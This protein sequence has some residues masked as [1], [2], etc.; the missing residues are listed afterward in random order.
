MLNCCFF[1]KNIL[2]MVQVCAL[3]SGSNGNCYY[4]GNEHE[5]VLI[6]AGINC[7]QILLRFE[8]AGLNPSKVKAIFIT[9]EHS[10]HVC[11]AKV[12]SKKLCVP[13][14]LTRGTYLNLIEPSRPQVFR[15]VEPGRELTI[16]NITV[17]PFRKKHD[18]A[19]PCSYRVEIEGR[20]IGVLTD[21]GSPC[22]ESIANLRLC[23]ILFLESNYD[24]KSLW[25]GP[26]PWPLKKRIASDLGHLSNLQALQLVEQHANG[27][28][29][30]IFLSHL[31]GE[32]NSPKMAAEAFLPL[33]EKYQ[34]ELTSRHG[35]GNVL[36]F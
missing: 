34:I 25:E 32:N 8:A 4:I 28:L 13:V 22:E 7:K 36:C 29:K 20:N 14:F 19:Q 16:G 10:D 15:F 6:D 35:A 12:L 23:E 18:A 5:A 24:E 21:L 11:G 26:Y 2:A 9:H 33:N 27:N 30:T 31:S 17:H 1:G 3:A